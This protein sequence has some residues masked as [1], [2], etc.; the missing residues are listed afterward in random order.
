[1]HLRPT[2]VVITCSLLSFFAL[3]QLFL[4]RVICVFE[5]ARDQSHV[6]TPEQSCSSFA[7]DQSFL[8]RLISVN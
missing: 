2:H 6:P 7:L 8:L 4:S 1:M 5:D 3:D